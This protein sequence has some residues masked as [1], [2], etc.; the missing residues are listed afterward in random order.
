MRNEYDCPVCNKGKLINKQNYFECNHIVTTE[1]KCN[2]Q[3]WKKN[4]NHILTSEQIESLINEGKTEVINGL[5]SKNGNE[6]DASFIIK[7]GTVQIEFNTSSEE[8]IVEGINCLCCGSNIIKTH[9][10]YQ[11]EGVRNNEC[12]IQV[13]KSKNG[14]VLDHET[15][16]TLLNGNK[17]QI[18][19]GFKNKEGELFNSKLLIDDST[20][21]VIFDSSIT[22]CPD[23]GGDIKKLDK[24]F[25]CENSF[26][27]NPNCSFVFFRDISGAHITEEIFLELL[28]DGK[29]KKP[30][31]FISKKTDKPFNAYL[32]YSSDRKI[33]FDFV[34]K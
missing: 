14:I 12:Y 30:L 33:N 23:C 7:D 17:T 29:T 16:M 9:N 26:G 21:K 1:D 19:K 5:I 4:Y 28:E 32:I 34:K 15:I 31:N 8:E 24:V 13:Y 2:F 11:C 20:Y 3:I 10:A 25:K 6:F 27:N 22:D 18:I